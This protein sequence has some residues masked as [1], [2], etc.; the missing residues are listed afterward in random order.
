MEAFEATE[1]IEPVA[2]LFDLDLIVPCLLIFHDFYVRMQQIRPIIFKFLFLQTPDPLYGRIEQK[3]RIRN[4]IPLLSLLDVVGSEL[5]YQFHLGYQVG[6]LRLR[7]YEQQ[8]RRHFIP[9]NH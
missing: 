6:N 8:N 1:R 3:E 9:G 4:R 5:R 2:A 7:N